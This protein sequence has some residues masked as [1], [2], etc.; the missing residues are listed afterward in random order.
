MAK[1]KI[2]NIKHN[3]VS[4][5]GLTNPWDFSPGSEDDT[6]G[7]SQ[8]AAGDYY[9][10]GIR[11]PMGKLRDAAGSRPVEKKELKIPPRSL[12]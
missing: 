1:Q 12:A 5:Y 11:N 8:P 6:K 10:T 2:K 7:N 3:K 9:G 4:G